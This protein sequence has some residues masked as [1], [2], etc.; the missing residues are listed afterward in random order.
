M[1]AQ[2]LQFNTLSPALPDFTARA[3]RLSVR[4]EAAGRATRGVSIYAQSLGPLLT[5]LGMDFEDDRI[6]A[7]IPLKEEFRLD[8]LLHTLCNLGL[9][10]E[11]IWLEAD[12][13]DPRV[14][15]GIY[16]CA[17]EKPEDEEEIYI[18]SPNP[19]GAPG[20]GV[21]AY[22]VRS[23]TTGIADLPQLGNG[24]LYSVRLQDTDALKLEQEARTVAK[25]GWFRSVF[26]R[27]QPM[28]WRLA[29][30]TSVISL[31]AM[32]VPVLI[33]LTYDRV[34]VSHAAADIPAIA[35]GFLLI[36]LAELLITNVRTRM[37]AWLSTRIDTIATH[38]II[39][40]LLQLPASLIEHATTASQISRI[41]G[42]EGI[43]DFFAG[44][45]FITVLEIPFTLLML[46]VLYAIGGSLALIPVVAAG[47]YLGMIFLLRPL[48]KRIMFRAAKRFGELQQ[49]TL[50]TFHSMA[51][52]RASG[53]Q[54]QWCKH[55]TD[56]SAEAVVTG[57]RSGF[58]SS[59]LET[60]AYAVTALAGLATLYLGVHQVLA[61]SLTAGALIASMILT[62]RIL[63]PMSMLCTMLPR[64]EQLR[65]TVAQLDRLM[66]LSSETDLLRT[67]TP[68][69]HLLGEITLNKV[70]L[71][72]NR[73]SEPVFAG[74]SLHVKPG[75]RVGIIGANG[76]G[77]STLL[78]LVMGLYVPQAGTVLI[79][80][81]DIR[82]YDAVELRQHMAYVPQSPDFFTG[83][84]AENLRLAR[85]SAS[86]QE[87][88]DA[89]L[90]A[91]AMEEIESLP[92][93]LDTEIQATGGIAS[94]SLFSFRLTLAR[95][96]LSRGEIV[97]CDELP[98]ALLS[99]EGD[100]HFRRL[101]ARWHGIRTVLIASHREDMIGECD[102]AVGLRSG[103]ATLVGKPS[104]VI[105]RLREDGYDSN[106]LAW[107]N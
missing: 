42:F 74:L 29:L 60:A 8:D 6:A 28:L 73:E 50:E 80:G 91:G 103:Q 66:K 26:R 11:R 27:F 63:A 22:H 55:A 40:K 14:L 61:G 30:A 77:K 1:N 107:A 75:Q 34:V 12:V 104:D 20:D 59:V 15:P 33:M 9:K 38:A 86:R 32:A 57:F 53:M 10:V 48:T 98:S 2:L 84:I 78:K 7:A 79:D 44:P 101:L 85:P 17:G 5:A 45:L 97:L 39:A 76:S 87:M 58:F 62:W 31:T 19:D 36:L 102:I 23:S 4:M 99:S 49:T 51:G 18:L 21:G 54:E 92:R 70:V 89:L 24:A 43:R 93:G 105:A 68:I 88:L 3:E 16:V 25:E 64:L 95:A 13:L 100:M 37:L 46:V 71:R 90:E 41:K 56:A 81:T 65:Q 69:P 82:Q 35:T 47:L 72:Y 83:S 94:P 106:Y 67:H 96:C 52:L